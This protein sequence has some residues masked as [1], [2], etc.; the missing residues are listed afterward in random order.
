VVGI[1]THHPHQHQE[2]NWHTFNI[3]QT[4]S[5][6][7][8]KNFMQLVNTIKG[9]KGPKTHQSPEWQVRMTIKNLAVKNE[10]QHGLTGGS[11][12]SWEYEENVGGCGVTNHY[13][14]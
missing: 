5:G 6:G 12:D 8:D 2:E 10:P 9:G 4:T 3:K 7:C 13:I 1:T 11:P 14:T